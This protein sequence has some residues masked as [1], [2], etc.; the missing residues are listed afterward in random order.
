M[1]F[2]NY[3]WTFAFQLLLIYSVNILYLTYICDRDS[4]FGIRPY[5]GNLNTGFRVSI[6]AFISW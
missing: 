1:D 5:S 6:K 3:L 2:E 4:V